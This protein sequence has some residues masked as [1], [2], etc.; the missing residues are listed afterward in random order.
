MVLATPGLLLALLP[1]WNQ[2]LRR[3]PWLIGAALLTAAL[4]YAWMVWRSQQSPLINF[5][6]SIDTWNYFW[7]YVSR[8]GYGGVDVTASAGWSDRWSFLWWFA[9]DLPRQLTL[10]GFVLAILGLGVL[11]RRGGRA[12][13]A[14]A[15]SGLL[16]LLGN[17][18]VLILLLGFDFDDLRLA[19]FRP[20]PLICYGVATLWLAAGMQWLLDRAPGWTAVRWPAR[21]TGMPGAN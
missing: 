6:G 2:V 17:S 16:A 12:A 9:E 13:I 21:S 7:F 19:I 1:V 8:Q 5:Y 14:S 3:L 20:Y 11:A 18:V 4:P 15:G 10:P